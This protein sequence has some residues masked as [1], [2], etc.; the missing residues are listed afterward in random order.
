MTVLALAKKWEGMRCLFRRDNLT[1]NPA[2][3]KRV[4]FSR[5]AKEC[6]ID[7]KAVAELY[8]EWTTVA[9][10][11]SRAPFPPLVRHKDLRSVTEERGDCYRLRHH[12]ACFSAAALDQEDISFATGYKY[13]EHYLKIMWRN[14]VKSLPCDIKPTP[15]SARATFLSPLPECWQKQHTTLTLRPVD[16]AGRMLKVA[17]PGSSTEDIALSSAPTTLAE[18]MAVDSDTED[19][20]VVRKREQKREREKMYASNRRREKASKFAALEYR[21]E[22]LRAEVY[23][24]VY[25]CVIRELL[26]HRGVGRR[27][28]ALGRR[29][30]RG[31][32]RVSKL[33][34]N[35]NPATWMLEVIGAGVG[36]SNDEKTDFVKLFQSSKH[37]QH[38]L[39]NLD[40]EGVSR[41][42]PLVHPLEY[43]D[44]RA[45]TE[46]TQRFSGCTGAR[47]HTT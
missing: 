43:S 33:E 20:Q 22:R 6:Q 41:P 42:S 14:M 39:S 25:C 9:G 10:D 4:A 16:A 29:Q 8:Y 24:T 31:A 11:A 45:A 1:K 34:A 38:L 19:N 21:V 12:T 46:L 26:L 3:D 30:G 18:T 15:G 32:G 27:G 36:N 7:R 37:F 35:Y 13:C 40:R 23:K 47:H 44:K 5:A 2:A 17:E 28:A